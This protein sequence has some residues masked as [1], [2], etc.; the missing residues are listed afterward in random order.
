VF[1]HKQTPAALAQAVRGFRP[2]QFDPLV[3][4]R[5]AEKF[6]IK[7]FQRRIAQFIAARLDN[8]RFQRPAGV[9]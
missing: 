4:R 6:D 3:I 1:F 8:T 9:L 7:H 5:H 2:D